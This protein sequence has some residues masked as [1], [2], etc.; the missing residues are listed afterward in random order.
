[1]LDEATAGLDVDAEGKL[2]KALLQQAKGKTTFVIA[3]GP[4]PIPAVD[5]IL[6]LKDG[7]IA[8]AGKHDELMRSDGY[9][10]S[11]VR[12]QAPLMQFQA[13]SS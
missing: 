6:V 9:Y 13:S 12:K 7:A 10:A 5:R 4:T 1:M 8:E 2:R 11:L 3:N